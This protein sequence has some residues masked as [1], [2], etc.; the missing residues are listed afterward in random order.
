MSV[1][2]HPEILPFHGAL[3]GKNPDLGPVSPVFVLSKTMLHADIL[4][5]PTDQFV[6]R[7]TRLW[8]ERTENRLLWRGRNTGAHFDALTN[9]RSSQRVRIVQ[10]AENQGNENMSLLPAPGEKISQSLGQAVVMLNR[11]VASDSLLDVAFTNAP[12]REFSPHVY[13][14][15]TLKFLFCASPSISYCLS[16]L[17]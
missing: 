3:T 2:D 8:I 13:N 15:A 12:I 17:Y 16:S 14:Q 6:E 4:G 1:C 10:F 9:W 5:I 7:D 11:Q